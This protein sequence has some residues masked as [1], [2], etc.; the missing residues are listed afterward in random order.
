MVK[1]HLQ[2]LD[3]LALLTPDEMGRADRAA[4]KGGICGI[5]LMENAG[6]AVAHRAG[7]MCRFGGH[8][9]VLAGPGNNGGDGFVAARLLAERGHP[10]RLALLGAPEKLV[11]DAA[12]A[13]SR[14][15]GEVEPLRPDLDLEAELIVDALFGAGLARELRGEV[16]ALVERVNACRVPVLAVDLPSGIDGRTGKVRGAAILAA[17]SVTFFRAKPGHLLLP[18]R[19]HAG[20][21]S[22]ADI[23]IPDEVLRPLRIRL[24]RNAPPLWRDALPWPQPG[25]HKYSRGHAVVVSGPAH[26]AGAARLAARAAL[27][28]GAGLVSVAAAPEAVPVLA[29]QLTAVMIKPAADAAALAEL[30]SDTRLNAVL[31]GPG[32]GTGDATRAKVLA[33]LESKAAVV[34]DADALTSFAA[35]PDRLFAAIAKR[36]A[37]AILTPHDGEFARLFPDLADNEDK[38]EKARLA[39]ARSRA[40]LLLKGADTVVAAPDG[41]ASLSA[42]DAPFLATAGTG[43]VLAGMAAGLAAQ[44]MPAFEAA[45]AA[46]WMHGEAARSFGP[47]LISEDLADLLPKVLAALAPQG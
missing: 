47:G 10:V 2:S 5:E 36:G 40:I 31:I 20:R 3:D 1:E 34:L 42:A 21:L 4:I 14:W 15:H 46:V 26:Q 12:L 18:G 22:V 13:A 6:R 37:P 43:D 32:V 8:V 35:A 9:L 7:E 39:A 44:A 30:L 29:S 11:G 17:E 23:G 19:L 27:R 33:C 28:I 45:S 41:R 25:G 16:A 24:C 38:V